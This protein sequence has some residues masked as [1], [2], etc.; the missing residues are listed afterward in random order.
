MYKSVEDANLDQIVT[1]VRLKSSF[2]YL[3]NAVRDLTGNWKVIALIL[4][5]LA[6]CASLCLL[7]DALNLQHLLV[8]KFEP[9]TQNV[10][11]LMVQ[12]PYRPAVEVPPLFPSWLTRSLHVLFIFII[13]ATDLVVLCMLK[14]IETGSR[15]MTALETARQIYTNAFFRVPSFAWVFFLQLVAVF[16][17]AVWTTFVMPVVIAILV[18]LLLVPGFLAFVWL[19][20]AQY[21]LVMDGYRSW[22]AMFYSRE[23]IRKRL[24]K[25]TLR[26]VVFLAVWSGYNSWAVATFSAVSLLLGLI[27]AITGALWVGVWIADLISVSA[28]LVATTFFLAAGQRLYQD[29]KA[30]SPQAAA[31]LAQTAMAPTA[32]LQSAAL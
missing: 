27:G 29:L 8:Q 17:L 32:P 20:V 22:L 12:E 15:G 5:P 24:W 21:A 3:G 31:A 26:I 14:W 19:C 23:L 30:S 16:P 7:P 9:G 4:A 6:V 18:V 25:V 10:G 13:A 11:W 1:E 2:I 28:L